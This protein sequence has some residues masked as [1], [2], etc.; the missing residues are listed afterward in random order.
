MGGS[1]I[2]YK[3]NYTTL[4]IKFEIKLYQK[5]KTHNNI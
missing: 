2:S 3:I 1:D 5:R 4:R